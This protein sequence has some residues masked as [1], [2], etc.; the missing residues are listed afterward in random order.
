MNGLRVTRNDGVF[1]APMVDVTAVWDEAH[2]EGYAEGKKEGAA[3]C[4]SKHWVTTATGDGSAGLS[5]DCPFEPDTISVFSFGETPVSGVHDIVS[6]QFDLKEAMSGG[7]CG[8]MLMMTNGT[9][10][11]LGN[12]G[13]G[14][15][16]TRSESGIVTL[17]GFKAQGQNDG[18]VYNGVFGNGKTYRIVAEK[19]T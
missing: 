8:T 18:I 10:R 1:V 5:F 11:L 7:I 12:F 2:A 16:Y 13:K 6:I 17:S 9:S 19:H 3:E 14:T 4:V 15:K